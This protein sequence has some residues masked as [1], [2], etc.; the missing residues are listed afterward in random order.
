MIYYIL[1]II[2]YIL[3]IIYYILYIIYYIL[4]KIYTSDEEGY[5]RYTQVMRRGI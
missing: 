5:I 4:Y 1:Y 3:Y 2:Y